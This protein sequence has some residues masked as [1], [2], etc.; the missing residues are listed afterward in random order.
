MAKGP[1]TANQHT[2]T[3]EIIRKDIVERVRK[4]FYLADRKKAREILTEA[5]DLGI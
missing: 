3:D 1:V 5:R 2:F 4:G